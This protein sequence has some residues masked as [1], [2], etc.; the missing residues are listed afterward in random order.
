[1]GDLG[2][3]WRPGSYFYVPEDQVEVITG[4]AR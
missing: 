4:G 3:D 1:M 2:Y